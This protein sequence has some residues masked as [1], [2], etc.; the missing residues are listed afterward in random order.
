MQVVVILEQVLLQEII[1]FLNND[2][3]HSKNFLNHL[4]ATLDKDKNIAS[5]QPKIKI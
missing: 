3:V 2:T 1:Y 5:V 4:V